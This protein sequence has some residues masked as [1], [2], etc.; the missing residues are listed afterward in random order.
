MSRLY[1]VCQTL[2][3]L[4]ESAVFC[5]SDVDMFVSLVCFVC[6]ML[7]CLGVSAVFCLSDVDMFV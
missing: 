1:S 2:I 6:Q 4:C 5:V 3:C 7:I